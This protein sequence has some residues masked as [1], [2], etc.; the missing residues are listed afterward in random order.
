[1]EI[2]F[3]IRS[4]TIDHCLTESHPEVK[5]PIR[6]QN[7][8]VIVNL[9]QT[10]FYRVNYDPEN[11]RRIARY[12]N[13]ERY[14]CIHVLNRAQIIDD[15][16][17]L[18]IEKK[19]NFSIFWEL[20]SYLPRQERDYLVWYP[21]IKALEYLS[22]YFA[23]M[24][25]SD[26]HLSSEFQDVSIKIKQMFEYKKNGIHPFLYEYHGIYNPMKPFQSKINENLKLDLTKWGCVINID[27]CLEMA[28]KILELYVQ[29]ST[30]NR[31]SPGWE[32]WTYCNGLK[33]ANESM[34]YTV[35]LMASRMYKE[36]S[37]YK[38]LEYLSC[39]ENP[40]IIVK[41]LWSVI[42][43]FKQDMLRK[44]Y[45]KMLKQKDKDKIYTVIT[46]M[47]LST[48]A[49]HAKNTLVLKEILTSYEINYKN[50]P[51]SVTTAFNVLINNAYTY[52][53][54]YDEIYEFAKK[55][56]PLS[57]Y[58]NYIYTKLITRY[59]KLHEREQFFYNL[60]K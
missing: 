6:N 43:E 55:Y 53:Q 22:N 33:T 48:L 54:L 60:F 58:K 17:H 31:I 23:I 4:S 46:N 28:K 15:A 39:S 57:K 9:Q 7:K 10:G 51:V 50:S 52:K 27:K 34:W 13:S 47:F 1:M 8:W 45:P 11:W 20:A 5:I 29:N 44:S 26:S 59:H 32:E 25:V 49:R 36:K 35:Y 18:M 12:L 19:L 16:F 14:T 24:K 37:D 30:L 38:M 41:Y 40:N 42:P 2:D 21:M 3:K 56:R